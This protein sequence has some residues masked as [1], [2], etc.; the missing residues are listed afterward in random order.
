MFEFNKLLF[1][2]DTSRLSS[3]AS[4]FLNKKGIPKKMDNY[5]IIRILCSH[6]NPI[7]LP[8]YVLDELFIIEVVRNY[9]FWFH[10][11]YERRK[12]QFIPLPLESW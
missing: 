8:Y 5:N 4:T 11:F 6:E 3:E 10:A 9:T 12:K 2:E 7:F 1:G